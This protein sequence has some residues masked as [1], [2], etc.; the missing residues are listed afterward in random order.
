MGIIGAPTTTPS[1][2]RRE[3]CIT[4]GTRRSARREDR[5]THEKVGEDG[6][7]KE[8]SPS[9]RF[10]GGRSKVYMRRM[11]RVRP[12]TK[13]LPGGSQDARLHEEARMDS[14]DQL[15]LRARFDLVFDRRF[16]EAI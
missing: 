8:R 6:S 2:G 1:R 13:E 4:S 9:Y 12:C 15:P 16:P 11:W 10:K 5:L 3:E 7:G 14:A